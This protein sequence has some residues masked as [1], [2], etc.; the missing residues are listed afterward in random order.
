MLSDS[1]ITSFRG[2]SKPI[3]LWR[4][5]PLTGSF[6]SYVSR[7]MSFYPI[8]VSLGC[9][10][11]VARITLTC[12]F[13]NNRTRLGGRNAILLTGWKGSPSTVNNPRIDSKETFCDGLF[14]LTFKLQR[15]VTNP[16]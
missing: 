5:F 11:Y 13:I 8:P 12:K 2:I 7:N 16:M 1:S 3:R 10:T 14:Y 9:A 6:V 15:S 4:L